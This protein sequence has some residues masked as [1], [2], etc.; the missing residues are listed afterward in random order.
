MPFGQS[1]P[2]KPLG[3]PWFVWLGG[4]AVVAYFLFFRNAGSQSAPTTSGGGG[5]VSTGRTTL[6]KGAVTINVNQ[7][8]ASKEGGKGGGQPE[9]PTHGRHRHEHVPTGQ[10]KHM[11]AITLEEAKR[12]YAEG[13]FVYAKD[14]QDNGYVR[15]RREPHK[16]EQFFTTRYEERHHPRIFA[17]HK[18]G[19]QGGTPP[20]PFPR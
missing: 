10:R 18:G 9:P 20:V 7:V 6:Q 1:E 13:G 11:E 15:V 16:G 19:P 8:P 12:L 5:S 3:L 4:A 14:K 17:H 2:G